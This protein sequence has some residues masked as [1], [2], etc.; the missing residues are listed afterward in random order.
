MPRLDAWNTAVF[1]ALVA[2]DAA[3]VETLCE[4]GRVLGPLCGE[5][6]RDGSG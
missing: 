5:M 4:R 1:A 3:F 6:G 2:D